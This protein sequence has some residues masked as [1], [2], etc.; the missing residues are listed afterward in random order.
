MNT[1]KQYTFILYFN[2]NFKDKDSG[3]TRGREWA[4]EKREGA[5]A[6]LKRLFENKAQFSCIAKDENGT[7]S[8]LLLR[9][10][11]NLNSPCTQAYAKG[12]LG[13]YSSCRPSYFGDMVSLCLSVHIDGDLTVIG[14][15]PRVGG[16]SIKKLKSFAGDPKLVVKILRESIDKR[17]FEQHKG[18]EEDKEGT[19][20]I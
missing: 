10:Y 19:R 7:A 15:L 9:G 18:E 12:L 4:E 6:Y 5:L 14:R 13:K 17:D 2:Y 8:C 11:M 1:T 16:N 3:L 20:L